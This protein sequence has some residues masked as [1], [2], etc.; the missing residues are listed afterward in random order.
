MILQL[1]QQM[2]VCVCVCVCA[3]LDMCYFQ[4]STLRCVFIDFCRTR[5]QDIVMPIGK[6]LAMHRTVQHRESQDMHGFTRKQLK[7]RICVDIIMFP[8]L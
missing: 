3:L 8:C 7:F 1:K 2:C 5:S 4:N 6:I